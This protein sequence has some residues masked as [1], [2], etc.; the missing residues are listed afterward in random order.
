MYYLRFAI[1]DSRCVKQLRLCLC[2]VCSVPVDH[3]CLCC[4]FIRNSRREKRLLPDA[5]AGGGLYGREKTG[6]EADRIPACDLLEYHNRSISRHQL[7]YGKLEQDMDYLALRRSYVC[8]GAG[9]SCS[10]ER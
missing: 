3:S 1:D 6:K 4:I 5:A 2:Y 7:L 8:G 9:V 10:I